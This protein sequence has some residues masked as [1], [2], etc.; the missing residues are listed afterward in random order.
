M[1]SPS[2]RSH[3]P[4]FAESANEHSLADLARKLRSLRDGDLAVVEAVAVGVR[5]IPTLREV[6]FEKDVAGVFEPR[7]RAVQAL[8]AL[9]AY[10]VLREFVASWR[11]TADPIRRMGDEA[12][13]SAAAR[14]LA[15][16]RDEQAFQVLFQAARRHPA[17]GVIEALG[18]YR[19]IE[20]IPILDAALGDDLLHAAAQDALR[21]L[22]RHA[23]PALVE[24]AAGSGR[25]RFSSEAFSEIRRRRSSLALLLELDAGADTWGKLN[26]LIDDPDDEVAILACRLGMTVA[27]DAGKR[28]CARRLVALLARAPWFFR[29]EIEDCLSANFTF[30]SEAIEQALHA[31]S[32]DCSG[33]GAARWKLKRSLQQVKTKALTQRARKLAP[34]AGNDFSASPIL[35]GP[36]RHE[37]P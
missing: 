21:K 26:H 1:T 7:R 8:A 14:A 12:A 36:P 29:A 13:L 28:A 37:P 6:L 24:I 10:D 23:I 17:S 2:S 31:L 16:A 18:E 22:G 20:L 9:G 35:P 25:D 27:D 32:K 15:G 11:P 3:S 30:A 5:A 19:R 34:H 4:P 33:D